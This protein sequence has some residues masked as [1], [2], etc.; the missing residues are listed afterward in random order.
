[1]NVGDIII[2][3]VRIKDV[4]DLIGEVTEIRDYNT[5]REIVFHKP[6]LIGKGPQDTKPEMIPISQVNPLIGDNIVFSS[7]TIIMYY[8]PKKQ[9]A[10]KYKALR[11]GIFAS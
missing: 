7:E 3:T 2:M 11:S 1:M 6:Y 4:L 8:S 9:Q 5:Y 10:D